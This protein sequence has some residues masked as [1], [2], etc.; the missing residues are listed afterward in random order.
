MQKNEH[1]T[2]AIC[3]GTVGGNPATKQRITTIGR[4]PSSDLVSLLEPLDLDSDILSC[5]RIPDSAAA[6]AC[7]QGNCWIVLP[8]DPGLRLVALCRFP[9]PS[10]AS[11]DPSL[12]SHRALF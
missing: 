11:G 10:L 9:D 3:L 8:L 12:G 4:Q 1:F 2:H 5:E 6:A 7:T